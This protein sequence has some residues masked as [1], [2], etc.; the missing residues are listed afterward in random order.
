MTDWNIENN[1]L[2]NLEQLAQAMVESDY[3]VLI[4]AMRGSVS[5]NSYFGVLVEE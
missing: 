4:Q 3:L 5:F 2:W 1:E